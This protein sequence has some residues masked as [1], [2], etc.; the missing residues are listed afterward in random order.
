METC[1]AH[2]PTW[3]FKTSS[4]GCPAPLWAVQVLWEGFIGF[5]RTPRNIGLSLSSFFLYTLFLW[6]Q[7]I[8]GQKS[9]AIRPPSIHQ[10]ISPD[11]VAQVSSD[12]TIG[13]HRLS[14]VLGSRG[15]LWPKGP[16]ER[17]Y[18]PSFRVCLSLC[19]VKGLGDDLFSWPDSR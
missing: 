19:P 12:D 18:P 9:F 13:C 10:E 15:T 3:A 4:R 2:F 5:P 14:S 8:P 6:H 11:P 1:W 7:P 16:L 17:G